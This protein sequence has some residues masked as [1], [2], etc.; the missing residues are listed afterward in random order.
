[1]AVGPRVGQAF[2]QQQAHALAPPGAVGRRGERLAP[3]V[4]GQSALAAERDERVRGGHDR[5]AAGQRQVALALPQRLRRQVQRD[6]R[7]RTGRVHRDR[8][9]FQPE[10]VGQ[11]AGHHAGG[12]AGQQVALQPVWRALQPGAGVALVA[13]ADEHTGAA[14]PHRVRRDAGA[15]ERLPRGFQQQPLLGVHGQRFPG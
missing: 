10:G 13:R 4:R 5:G 7:G 11:P 14:A 6:Q 2:Q 12:V 8:G 15:F 3:A 1:M 9:A